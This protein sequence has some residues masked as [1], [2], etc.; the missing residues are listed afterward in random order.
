LAESHSDAYFEWLTTERRVGDIVRRTT[1][2]FGGLGIW[3]PSQDARA[4][5]GHATGLDFTGL[6]VLADRI[7][8]DAERQH[9]ARLVGRRL[10]HESVG[11]ILGSRDFRGLELEVS[12]AT[13]E[14]REDT[15]IIVETALAYLARTGLERPVIADL[16]T[17]SGAILIA[18]LCARPEA[19]GVAIDISPEALETATRNAVRHKIESRWL[20]FVGSYA[21]ALSPLGFDIIVSNPPYIATSEI[22][23]LD[24]DVR[25]YDPHLALDGGKDGLD[26]YR[27]IVPD[28]SAALRP[29]G[30][31]LLEIGST[32]GAAVVDIVHQA[33]FTEVQLISDRGGRDRVVLGVLPGS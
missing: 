16:G 29:G 4:L 11:R 19:L 6:V 3:G 22:A 25:D 27:A 32:Q 9:I 7:A 8:T 23:R 13:L 31:L 28:A 5:V 33:G 2:L 21:T 17:G 10:A 1:R 15:E 20:P 26:A 14:P 18:I 24:A 30:A 12:P